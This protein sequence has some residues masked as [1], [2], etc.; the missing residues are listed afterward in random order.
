M[1]AYRIRNVLHLYEPLRGTTE[2]EARLHATTLYNGLRFDD[3]MVIPCMSRDCSGV[4]SGRS[5]RSKNPTTRFRLAVNIRTFVNLVLN[6]PHG[7]SPWIR[8]SS[9]RHR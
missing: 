8:R 9:C 5:P 7:G 3:Q 4:P 1:L 2:I 6:R